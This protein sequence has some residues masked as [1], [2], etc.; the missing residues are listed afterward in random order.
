M[1]LCNHMDTKVGDLKSKMLNNEYVRRL[2]ETIKGH[3]EFAIDQAERSKL[4]I[5]VRVRHPLE[6]VEYEIGLR[7]L[8]IRRPVHEYKPADEKEAYKISMELWERCELHYV[9]KAKVSPVVYVTVIDEDVK[10][11]YTVNMKSF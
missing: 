8:L 3:H 9:I 7:F 4:R 11:V 2:V 6:F 5:N 1:P 10:R